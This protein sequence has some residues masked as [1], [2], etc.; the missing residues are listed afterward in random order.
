[1]DLSVSLGP[2]RLR[3][4][5]LLASGTFGGRQPEALDVGRLGGV[6]LKTLTR[7]PRKGNPPPRIHE[8]AA[9]ML[10]SIGLENK[11]IAAFLR[12]ELP[13]ALRYRTKVVVSLA[14]RDEADYAAMARAL[15]RF[16]RIAALELNI[17]CPN[18]SEGLDYGTDPRLARRVVSA[19]R[20]AS[21]FPVIAKLTPNVTDVVEIARA[22][23]DGGAHA[24]SL[25]NTLKGLAVDWRRR[26]PVLGA[27]TGG[28]SGPAIKPVA[29]RMVWEVARALPDRPVIGIGGIATPEDAME[30]L[31]A[32]ACAVQIGTAS[33]VDVNASTCIL[34]R[35]PALLAAAGA[36]RLRDYVGTMQGPGRR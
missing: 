20:A 7:E 6:V 18:V 10:N 1:M 3:N 22:A 35:L 24:V 19:V 15:N 31:C 4:P 2:L 28:L 30:F 29:L 13:R 5:V 16:P 17:S 11:G 23:F 27:V 36:R 21:R 9:G 25:V 12:T 33:F 8:T 32:G 34:D 26:R 14:G